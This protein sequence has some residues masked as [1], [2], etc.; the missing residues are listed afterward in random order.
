MKPRTS[1]VN[2]VSYIG[3]QIYKID[4]PTRSSKRISS[5]M[6]DTGLYDIKMW[7]TI[8]LRR[9][10]IKRNTLKKQSVKNIGVG[11]PLLI[12][13]DLFDTLSIF[14]D[15]VAPTR[16]RGTEDVALSGEPS[17]IIC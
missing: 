17:N 14:P 13:L 11:P 8:L 10:S 5:P 3:S 6:H 4:M 1:E 9:K 12:L 2:E 7:M 16:I 15:H